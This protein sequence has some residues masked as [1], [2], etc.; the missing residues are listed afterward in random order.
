MSSFIASRHRRKLRGHCCFEYVQDSN[1]LSTTP[2]FYNSITTNCT[3]TIVKMMRAV[4]DVVPLD[5]RLI[6]NGYL[7]EYAY[8]RGALDTS[9][10]LADLR[11]LAHIDQRAKAAG[12]GPDFS[13]LIR[14]DVPSPA[15]PQNSGKIPSG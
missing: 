10:P 13:R 1:A 4:G 11:Q 2:E 5:W 6:V 14:V 12:L 9:L 3:T 15:E 7:P 8:E